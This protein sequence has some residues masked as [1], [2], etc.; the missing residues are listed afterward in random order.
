[1]LEDQPDL[2]CECQD[3]QGYIDIV[4]KGK[5]SGLINKSHSDPSYSETILK[6]IWVVHVILKWSQNFFEDTKQTKVGFIFGDCVS[7]FPI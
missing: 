4:S 7:C 2:Q 5:K 3:S 1:M 6:N